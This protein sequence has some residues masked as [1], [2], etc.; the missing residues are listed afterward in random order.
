ML[1]TWSPGEQHD[2]D[3]DEVRERRV[4]RHHPGCRWL[5]DTSAE[6][7]PKTVAT[8][9]PVFSRMVFAGATARNRARPCI[10]P[11]VLGDLPF[12]IDHLRCRSVCPQGG[13][14]EHAGLRKSGASSTER[15]PRAGS[16]LSMCEV[17]GTGVRKQ[18][19][20]PV[21]DRHRGR[22]DTDSRRSVLRSQRLC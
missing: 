18:L 7:E 14:A 19:A 21:G 4:G 13:M 15:N 2:A 5:L 8:S 22:D 17:S 1:Q 10:G 20:H 6:P 16:P 9:I 12:S 3:S 11:T